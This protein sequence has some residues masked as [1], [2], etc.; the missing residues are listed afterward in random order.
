MFWDGDYS[1]PMVRLGMHEYV[2]KPLRVPFPHGQIEYQHAVDATF[3]YV[4]MTSLMFEDDLRQMIET[5]SGTLSTSRNKPAGY[6]FWRTAVKYSACTVE[7][8]AT[9]KSMTLSKHVASATSFES[10]VPSPIL[11]IRDLAYTEET[12]RFLHD[13]TYGLFHQNPVYMT[14]ALVKYMKQAISDGKAENIHMCNH[15]YSLVKS[16]KAGLAVNLVINAKSLP[17]CLLCFGKKNVNVRRIL[18][19][20]TIKMCPWCCKPVNVVVK[21]K[22]SVGGA[23]RSQI[24]TDDYTQEPLY[25]ME[26]NHRGILRFPLIAFTGG[27]F[28]SNDLVWTINSRFTQVF[29]VQPSPKG[30]GA[31][32]AILN[33]QTRAVVYVPV[34]TDLDDCQNTCLLCTSI[35]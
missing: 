14:R 15:L 32:M 3:E 34:E 33:Q 12:L 10:I 35:K 22:S 23:H 1:N 7:A 31:R 4:S 17:K 27:S 5:Q 19:L 21:K 30:R 18:E 6:E 29:T 25:C 8:M 28:V 9:S 26:K 16:H 24:F 2:F 20:F 13:L 11:D